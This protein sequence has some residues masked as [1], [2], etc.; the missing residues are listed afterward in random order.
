MRRTARP[1]L[2][3]VGVALAVAACGSGQGSGAPSASASGTASGADPLA[4]AEAAAGRLGKTLRARLEEVLK[5][6]G[7]AA[8]VAVCAAEAQALGTQIASETGVRVGRASLRLR[9]PADAGPD[10]VAAWLRAQGERPA[11]GVAPVRELVDGPTGKVARVLK[12][13]AVDKPCLAC[14]GQPAELAAEVTPAL[15]ATYPDDAAVGYREGDLRG[16][17]WAELPVGR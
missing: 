1:L 2:L 6:S 11:E 12:P 8:A 13:I 3:V 16:A 14:H 4:R 5:A 7:P 10:W 17:L 9:N 15:A